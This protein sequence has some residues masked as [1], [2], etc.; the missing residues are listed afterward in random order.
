MA[1]KKRKKSPWLLVPSHKPDD[2]LYNRRLLSYFALA[3]SAVWFQ[4]V[5]FVVFIAVF[6]DRAL[7]AAIIASLLTAPASLAGL[8]YWKYL[9]ASKDNDKKEKPLE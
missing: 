6:L 9:Q 4:Q 2:Q 1:K 3:Y 8:G 5:L 7:D